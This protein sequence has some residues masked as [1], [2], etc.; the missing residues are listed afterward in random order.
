MDSLLVFAIVSALIALHEYGHLLAARAVGIPIARFSV[1]M[2]PSIASFRHGGTEYCLGI[3]PFGGY[4][5]PE[6]ESEQDYF[7]FDPGRRVVFALGGPVVNI[8]AACMLFALS[9]CVTDRTILGVLDFAVT[10]TADTFLGTFALLPTLFEHPDQLSGVVGIVAEGSQWTSAG[11][12]ASLS[13]AAL[14]SINLAV[15]N[16]LPLPPLDGGKVVLC[17]LEYV[18]GDTQRW[19]LPVSLAGWAL[20]LGLF[21]YVTVLDV[22]RLGA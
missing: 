6:L 12:A 1:G 9:A 16:L 13:F 21:V 15:L 20:F 11:A 8:V 17:L 19:H 22:A 18:Y 2:G 3:L 10:R 4:V 7:R 14:L 5:M